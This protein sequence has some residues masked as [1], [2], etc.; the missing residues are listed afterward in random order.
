M[1]PGVGG[2]GGRI[3]LDPGMQGSKL[4]AEL[5][6]ALLEKSLSKELAVG[7]RDPPPPPRLKNLFCLPNQLLLKNPTPGAVI[8]AR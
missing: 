3:A 6:T 7:L 1:V 4:K 2:Q 8:P 5:A